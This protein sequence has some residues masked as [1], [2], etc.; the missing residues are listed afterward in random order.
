[1]SEDR[2]KLCEEPLPKLA[3]TLSNSVAIEHG[4][5]CWICMLSHLKSEEAYSFLE[6]KIKENLEKRRRG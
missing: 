4:Y 3:L 1:M 6:K 5:C 2:C